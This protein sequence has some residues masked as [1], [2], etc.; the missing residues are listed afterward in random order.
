VAPPELVLPPL[1]VAPPELVL[2]PLPVAPPELFEPPLPVAPPE[3]FE[4]PL[5]VEPPELTEPP[6]PV[7]PPELFEPPLPVEP[8]E[9]FEPPLPLEPPELFEPPL[10]FE[11]PELLEPP[12][13]V[14]PP[15]FAAQPAKIRASPTPEID[16]RAVFMRSIIPDRPESDLGSLPLTPPSTSRT[17]A[18]TFGIRRLCTTVRGRVF[19]Y[20][21]GFSYL[22]P[23]QAPERRRRRP[24]PA[25][26]GWRKSGG[27]E[28]RP[29]HLASSGVGPVS[30][31]SDAAVHI[32]ATEK[33]NP[34][35]AVIV[36]DGS[37]G[38]PAADPKNR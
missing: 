8:P 25:P 5:P 21:A 17:K 12:L 14:W 31:A 6:L 4:P 13:P 30:G 29:R 35:S 28:S 33:P 18:R 9:L 15:L 23:G 11:P 37:D 32:P 27:G 38:E 7:A 34:C 10:P 3:L 2:P 16:R 20:F 19:A 36:I 1:P 24:P 26:N 22:V